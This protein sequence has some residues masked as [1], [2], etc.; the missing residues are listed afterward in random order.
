MI[1]RPLLVAAL[2]VV[3]LFGLRHP[4]RAD[5]AAPPTLPALA[6]ARAEAAGR[7][8]AAVDAQWRSGSAT[9][10][11]VYVWSVRWYGA[12]RAVNAT[13]AA[14]DHLKRMQ[15][16]EQLVKVKVQMGAAPVSDGAQVVFYRSEAELFAAEGTANQVGTKRQ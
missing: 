9:L 14:A 1:A 3:V 6:Q 5:A 12:A 8:Y 2:L 13:G 7:A 10:D 15:A 16:I 4:A 11:S